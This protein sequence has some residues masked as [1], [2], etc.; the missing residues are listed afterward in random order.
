MIIIKTMAYYIFIYFSGIQDLFTKI[1]R[2]LIEIV[3]SS[4][5]PVNLKLEIDRSVFLHHY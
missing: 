1:G 4:K 5:P 2:N 3:E